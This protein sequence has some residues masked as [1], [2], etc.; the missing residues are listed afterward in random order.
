M[1]R[2]ALTTT[3]NKF[4]PIL[5][6]WNWLDWDKTHNYGTCEL[7][8]RRCPSPETESIPDEVIEGIKED[9]IDRWVKMF[10]ES[11]AK[12]VHEIDD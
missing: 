12:V 9:F 5:D 10:P 8:A 7:V 3:D 6:F 1:R 2:V 4:D 11:Y